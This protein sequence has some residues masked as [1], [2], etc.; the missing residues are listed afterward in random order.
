MDMDIVLTE[1]FKRGDMPKIE[2]FRSTVHEHP[3]CTPADRRIAI[4]SDVPVEANCP[5]FHIDDA[6]GIADFLEERFLQRAR[7]SG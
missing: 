5:R 3:L 2:V 7:E 1:G 4:A 6:E